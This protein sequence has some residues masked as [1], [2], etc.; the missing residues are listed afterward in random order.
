MR[1]AGL[2]SGNA[3][4]ILKF[5]VGETF[6]AAGVPAV[7]AGSNDGGVKK[8]TTITAVS[9]V[10]VTLDT[11]TYA[12]AQTSSGADPSAMVSVII[13]PNAIW[14]AKL[15]GGATENTALSLGTEDTGST[16][17]LL[18]STNVDYSSPSF[19]EGLIWCTLG[20]NA[21][22][23]RK[24]TSLSGAD[25]V[26]SVA[27]TNDTAI[28]DQFIALPFNFM[29][30]QFVQLST[31]LTQVNASVT[32]DTDNAN[33]IPLRLIQPADLNQA[34]TGALIDMVLYDSIYANGAQ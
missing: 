2:L 13:N 17:G 16:T 5:Q 34:V 4:C 8:A 26:P 14:Q 31:L 1:F 20:A 27:F 12:T 3:P 22:A 29:G 28:G 30:K 19:D 15:S 21:G 32:I 18:V 9:A 25:A 11:A 6:A 23:A 7:V 10:G 33:F 24:I